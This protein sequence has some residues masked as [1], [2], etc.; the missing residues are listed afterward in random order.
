M[1]K[2]IF[3]LPSA[4]APMFI[5]VFL[6]V[7]LVL[8]CSSVSNSCEESK[9]SADQKYD[10]TLTLT[11]K[12]RNE[13]ILKENGE[14]V[15]ANTNTSLINANILN[16]IKSNAKIKSVDY[17]T[18]EFFFQVGI[19]CPQ[20]VFEQINNA[21]L[22]GGTFSGVLKSYSSDNNTRYDIGAVGCTDEKYIPSALGADELELKVSY[23]DNCSFEDGIIISKKLYE[24]YE[25]PEAIVIGWYSTRTSGKFTETEDGRYFLDNELKE[26]L[27]EL[28]TKPDAP[29]LTIKVAG[30]YECDVEDM[31]IC[32]TDLWSKIYNA[33]DYYNYETGTQ[34]YYRDN[35]NAFD[36]CGIA[37]LKA[38]LFSPKETVD[39]IQELVGLGINTDDYLITANDFDYKFAVS[40]IDGIHRFSET[41][42]IVSMAFGIIITLIMV[43]YS[44]KKRR[45]EIYTLLT[46]G[47]SKSSITANISMEISLVLMVAVVVAFLCG[48]LLGNSI[49]DYLNDKICSSAISSAT[50]LSRI[51]D[52]L[53]DNDVLKA[54]L[55]SAVNKYLDVGFL[56]GYRVS[57]AVYLLLLAF[58][59]VM[60]LIAWIIS[61]VSV[62][63]NLMSGGNHK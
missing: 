29:K 60:S 1:L 33:Q 38:E 21:V 19:M 34:N 20:S 44:V 24:M 36:E 9:K 4:F 6:T 12:E 46:L 15:F 14:Y 7:V 55:A 61:Y 63:I 18:N 26:H 31:I 3:R 52:F 54:Q 16:V 8:I 25:Q 49:F 45:C 5:S 51:S 37:V 57:T 32:P 50:N 47:K 30:Y 58:W 28:L 42:Y 13:Y 39:V 2:N 59:L 17:I 11:L 23:C 43:Y 40:Q 27:D 22:T 48:L 35:I 56:I 41:I 10:V 62:S 53:K